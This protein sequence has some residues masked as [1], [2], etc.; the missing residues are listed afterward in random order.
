MYCNNTVYIFKNIKNGS[1]DTI[2]IFKNYFVTIF[3]VF[4]FRNVSLSS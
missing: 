2:Y 3:S 4:N 1:Y